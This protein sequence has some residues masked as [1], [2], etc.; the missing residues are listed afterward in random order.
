M[1]AVLKKAVKL[2]HSHSLGQVMAWWRQASRWWLVAW[3][4]QAITWTISDQWFNQTCQLW[5]KYLVRIGSG[6]GLVPDGTK[7]SPEPMLTNELINPVSCVW[8]AAWRCPLHVSIMSHQQTCA[9][10][11]IQSQYWSV[12][13]QQHLAPGPWLDYPWHAQWTYWDFI[14]SNKQLWPS[15]APLT[16]ID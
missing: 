8:S 13:H 12:S 14:Q 5:V 10:S 2:N 9:C 4:H 7:P 11:L 15:G 1:S 16:N 6:D 3:C